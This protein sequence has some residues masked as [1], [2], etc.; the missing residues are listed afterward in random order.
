MS[1]AK[2]YQ[3]I[4]S[5][6]GNSETLTKNPAGWDNIGISL[7]RNKTY[8]SIPRSLTLSLRFANKNGGGYE[9]IKNAYDKSGI[10]AN[11][12]ITINKR[13]SETNSYELLYSGKLDL[14]PGRFSIS[15]N[16]IEVPIIDS[17]KVQR[18]FSR[19]EISYNLFS[20][21]STDGASITPFASEKSINLTPI[22]IILQ[23]VYGCNCYVNGTYTNLISYFDNKVDIINQIGER[24]T[25][26]GEERFYT[27][28]TQNDVILSINING[29]LNWNGSVGFADIEQEMRI[30]DESNNFK[31]RFLLHSAK[32]Y[33]VFSVA[34]S[35]DI[36]FKM[37]LDV[38]D[39]IIFRTKINNLAAE[40]T[41]NQK[42]DYTISVNEKSPGYPTTQTK[43][44]F[45][46]EAFTR[47]VQLTTSEPSTDKL[48]YSEVMGSATSEFI[49]Y[50][51]EGEISKDAIFS[52]L[53]CR[54]YPNSPINVT[55]KELFKSF[56]AIY[57][58]GFGYDQINDRFYI[59]PKSSFFDANRFMFALGEVDDLKITPLQDGYFGKV[60]AGY[61]NTGDYEDLQGA[62]EFNGKVEY[63]LPAPVKDE[64][65][66]Q[67]KYRAD[68]V[69]I[70]ITRKKQ[71]KTNISEDTNNDNSV[72]IVKTDG[73]NPILST[74]ISGFVGCENYYNSAISPRS[75]AVRWGNM[76]KSA[77]YKNNGNLNYQKSEKLFSL[78]ID[79]IDENSSVLQSEM[80][81]PLIIPELYTF[82]SYL[83]LEMVNILRENPHGFISFTY[84]GIGYEGYIDELQ[85]SDNNKKANFKLIAKAP[86]ELNNFI[87]F[88]SNDF[89]FFDNNDFIFYNQ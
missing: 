19:D 54:Q 46:H 35:I 52:G 86:S 75:N 27:N 26:D 45:P 68:S 56:D 9:F 37:N 21:V 38:G 16:Y 73:A 42:D 2:K 12:E 11:I 17:Q 23:G 82:E 28:S 14:N 39:F 32:V 67:S 89:Y 4:L 7:V 53:M 64:L 18:L 78:T 1:I 85:M 49:T 50:P 76:I 80:G 58:L 87:F 30:Y 22:D 71:Y 29:T 88:D 57:N 44:L 55:L 31:E 74:N 43:C 60:I 51:N 47:L 65:E 83:T 6:D 70:E 10:Y 69:G 8:H 79:G 48:F 40:I 61:D 36:D 77:L 24:I 33:N 20:L 72:F 5:F 3:Y 63:S 41:F 81:E 84:N 13:S 62:Y 25:I 34:K 66:I 15:R 59:A